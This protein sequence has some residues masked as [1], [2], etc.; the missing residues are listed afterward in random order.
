MTPAQFIAGLGA[1]EGVIPA[2]VGI[3]AFISVIVVWF[4]LL[5]PDAMGTRI[6]SLDARRSELRGARLVVQRHPLRAKGLGVASNVVHRL[7]LLQSDQAKKIGD[8]LAQAGWRSKDAVVVYLF[9][10]VAG[11]V[12]FGAVA[13]VVVY[14]LGLGDLPSLGRLFVALGAVL[15]GAYFPE[16]VTKNTAKRRRQKITKAMPDA[17]DLMVICAEAGLSLDASLERV[18]R[19][20]NGPWPEMSDEATLTSIELSFVP[21]RRLALQNLARRVPLSGV[22]GLV[23]TLVQTERYGTPLATALRVLSREMRNT[24]LMAAET[25]AARLP[26]IMT[27]PMII[28]ILPTL[29][30][31]LLGPA[32]LDIADGLKGVL[33]R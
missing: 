11:P 10:K 7:K 14:M 33:A 5:Q 28:F 16:I 12:V 20:L 15:L 3:V 17:L 23:N 9:G 13:V 21:D 24:R 18:G 8:K 4:G 26:A 2:L 25:K 1:P 22:R 32:G 30:V 6:K 19:E 27:V 31:V 29:F